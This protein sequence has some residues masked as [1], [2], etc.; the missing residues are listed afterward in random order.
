[1]NPEEQTL[2]AKLQQ[3]PLDAPGVALP[4]S[5]RLAQE[6][7]WPAAYAHRVLAEYKKFV[8][9][10]CTSPEG[11]SP[12]APV[13]AAWHLHLTY[14]QAYWGAFCR[15]TLGRE[16]HHVPTQGGPAEAQKHQSA[17]VRTLASYRQIFGQEP[18][19]DIWPA[20]GTRLPT[21]TWVPVD[22]RTHWVV[23]K[24]SHQ[25]QQR[26]GLVALLVVALVSVQALNWLGLGM[27]LLAV[28]V[29]G[30][31]FISYLRGQQRAKRRRKKPQAKKTTAKAPA[32]FNQTSN[33]PDD[34]LHHAAAMYTLHNS[35]DGDPTDP[36]F[37]N[38]YE[39]DD[40][41]DG[42]EGEDNDDGSFD[43]GQGSDSTSYD[44]GS[45]DSGG[46]DSSCSSC[47]SCGS[48]D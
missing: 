2:W 35:L 1:M 43:G 6:N 24:P 30:Y 37:D 20:P 17:Y 39:Y 29:L 40:A 27:A 23:P 45:S 25:W 21:R 14:T 5:A 9:L 19:A 38:E 16:L 22:P 34:G 4:F 41:E 32:N 44:S 48:S 18:P 31:V 10:C 15:D 28:G 36:D 47:S 46:S 11:A 7:R 3:F 26:L 42:F 33:Q 8:F 12:S 13:D